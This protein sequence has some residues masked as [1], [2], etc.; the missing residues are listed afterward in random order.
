[1]DKRTVVM[2]LL[3]KFEDEAISIEKM[4]ME[5]VKNASQK[6]DDDITYEI[7]RLNMETEQRLGE[8]RKGFVER[9]DN[10][11]KKGEE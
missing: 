9:I 8:I 5:K 7:F 10:L 11:Y 4:R 6:K 1:M 3:Q 2:R